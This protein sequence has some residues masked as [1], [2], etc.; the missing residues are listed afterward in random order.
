MNKI[1][2]FVH[3]NKHYLLY[4]I[5]HYLHLHLHIKLLVAFLKYNLDI[6]VPIFSNLYLILLIIFF[7]N[8]NLVDK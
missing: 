2:L 5:K 7:D 6:K 3:N 1:S 4:F 8:F